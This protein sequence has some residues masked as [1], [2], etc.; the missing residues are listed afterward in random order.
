[1]LDKLRNDLP[2][3]SAD[4]RAI[5]LEIAAWLK[6]HQP[7]C[8]QVAANNGVLRFIL[9]ESQATLEEAYD[10]LPSTYGDTSFK[11][12]PDRSS[13]RGRRVARHYSNTQD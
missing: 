5:E 3:T 12:M 13:Q 9:T 6:E 4:I 1:M 10:S 11:C 7:Q 2:L 8:D